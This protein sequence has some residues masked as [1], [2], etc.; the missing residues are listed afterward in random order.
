MARMMSVRFTADAVIERRKT[1]TRRKGWWRRDGSP[2]VT[3]GD[4]LRLVRQAMGLRKGETVEELARV[5]VT[6]IGREPLRALLTDAPVYGRVEMV[7][8][9]FPGLPPQEFID[10]YFT[11]Q[12]IGLNDDVTRIQWEYLN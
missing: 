7:R 2:L 11:P 6:A 9:G 8:E 10:R 4:E 5:R 12:G 3:P 1:V